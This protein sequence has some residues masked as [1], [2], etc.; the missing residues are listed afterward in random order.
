MGRRAAFGLGGRGDRELIRLRSTGEDAESVRYT[1]R[2]YGPIAQLVERMA[3]SHEVRGSN[4]LGSTNAIDSEARSERRTPVRR[5][6]SVRLLYELSVQGLAQTTEGFPRG[7]A[8]VLDFL[9]SPLY[10]LDRLPLL[11]HDAPSRGDTR[12][13]RGK[14]RGVG[15]NGRI[16]INHAS[17]LALVR[18]L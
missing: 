11:I 17:T 12:D 9:G 6:S 3:G 5:G 8:L 16:A 10:L 1:D 18:G 4:P 7:L 2:S 13:E 15:G 14:A